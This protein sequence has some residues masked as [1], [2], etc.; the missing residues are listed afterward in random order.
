MNNQDLQVLN[1]NF[2][3][4]D[5]AIKALAT[6]V[7]SVKSE[8]AGISFIAKKQEERSYQDNNTLNRFNEVGVTNPLEADLDANNFDVENIKDFSATNGKFT[9]LKVGDVAITG[10]IT[11]FIDLTDTPTE[12]RPGDAGRAVR[13]NTAGNALEFGPTFAPDLVVTKNGTQLSQVTGGSN[14]TVLYDQNGNPFASGSRWGDISLLPA[15]GTTAHGL[16]VDVNAEFVFN[17]DVAV[18]MVHSTY[19]LGNASLTVDTSKWWEI[20]TSTLANGHREHIYWDPS[21]TISST[22]HTTKLYF[23]IFPA[24]TFTLDNSAPF[25]FFKPFPS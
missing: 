4:I 6:E 9:S 14:G 16:G 1:I 23:R 5:A 11:T 20:S 13:V 12:V 2:Q 15:I 25:Y 8:L 24:G 19:W 21:V 3:K 10:E 18:Y 7:A 17:T 22:Y